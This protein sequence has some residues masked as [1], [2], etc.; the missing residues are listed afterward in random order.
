MAGVNLT[1]EQVARIKRIIGEEYVF[2]DKESLGKVSM[3]E[4]EDLTYFPEVLIKPTTP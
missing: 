1:N 4:T 3:D 2:L